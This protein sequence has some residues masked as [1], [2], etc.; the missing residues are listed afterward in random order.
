MIKRVLILGFVSAIMFSSC[1][2]GKNAENTDGT[3]SVDENTLG[4]D[5]VIMANTPCVKASNTDLVKS[6]H[7]LW[8]KLQQQYKKLSLS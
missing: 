2:G 6:Y 4:L 3:K 7:L 8:E 5:L 1:G